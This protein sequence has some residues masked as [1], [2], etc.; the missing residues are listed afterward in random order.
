MRNAR[1]TA[2]MFARSAPEMSRASSVG[3]GSGGSDAMALPFGDA[4]G[5]ADR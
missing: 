1:T 5:K 4:Q 3:V 2:T